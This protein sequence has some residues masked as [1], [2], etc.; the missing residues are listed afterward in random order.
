MA[1]TLGDNFSYQA[2]KPLDARLK[3]DTVAA[4]K[5][6]AD[7][8]MYEGCLA[9]CVATDKTYQ[10]KS[11]NTVD[12]TLGKW[13]E[14]GAPAM[15]SEDMPSVMTP[16]PSYSGGSA[17]PTGT[18]ISFMGVYA[19]QGYLKCDGTVYNIADY[20]RLADFFKAQFGSANHFGGDGTTTFAVPNLLGEFL[21]MTGTNSHTDQGSG[22]A[23]GVHQD[24]TSQILHTI[25]ISNKK[26]QV[27]TNQDWFM[28]YQNADKATNTK[29]YSELFFSSANKLVSDTDIIA[30]YTVRPTN[31]SVLYCIKD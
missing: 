13:R 31:T 17:N 28:P 15:P 18:I 8:T 23:V 19:P 1:L 5:A 7:S 27:R 25:D 12:A 29:D 26:Y 14:Y 24:G 20:Q 10:W 6:V 11:T 4:M 22:A 2:S 9:Y 3:Y 16:L 21:R 30:S